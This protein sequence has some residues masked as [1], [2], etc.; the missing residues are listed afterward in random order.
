MLLLDYDSIAEYD[1]YRG[2]QHGGS[3]EPGIYFT[4]FNHGNLI[5][6]NTQNYSA[7]SM[8]RRKVYEQLGG[9]NKDVPDE[10]IPPVS[11][12]LVVIEKTPGELAVNDGT[13]QLGDKYINEATKRKIKE[14]YKSMTDSYKNSQEDDNNWSSL[15][16]STPIAQRMLSSNFTWP[17]AK[18][19]SGLNLL[20]MFGG[21]CIMVLLPSVMFWQI[22]KGNATIMYWVAKIWK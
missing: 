21:A 13:E 3:K 4:K 9:E 2:D 16:L 22:I 14:A 20:F 8:N 6:I 11:Q 5:A 12:E 7:L 1:S 19:I 18:F 10:V 15:F 17:N